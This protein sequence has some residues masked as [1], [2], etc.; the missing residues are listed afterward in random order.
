MEEHWA[1]KPY[2]L[3]LVRKMWP[4]I[5]A[6]LKLFCSLIGLLLMLGLLHRAKAGPRGEAA[7]SRRS[8]D[9]WEQRSKLP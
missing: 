5:P 3:P 1:G 6:S 2:C 9:P 7:R 8:P 4:H